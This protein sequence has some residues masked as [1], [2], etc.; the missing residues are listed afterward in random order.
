MF[1]A[2]VGRTD[3]HEMSFDGRTHQITFN[4]AHKI[5]FASSDTTPGLQLADL[6]AGAASLALK[7]PDDEFSRHWREGSSGAMH[8]SSVLP[9][10]SEVDLDTERAVVNALVLQE[11]VDRSVRGVSLLRGVSEFIEFAQESAPRILLEHAE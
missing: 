1:D 2:F 11:L 3:Y 6:V 9:D 8:S 7:S 4:L 10:L 5:R